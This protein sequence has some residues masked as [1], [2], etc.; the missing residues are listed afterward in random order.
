MGLIKFRSVD[1]KQPDEHLF[2]CYFFI[3]VEVCLES[4]TIDGF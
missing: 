3:S 4:I 2:S 1:I